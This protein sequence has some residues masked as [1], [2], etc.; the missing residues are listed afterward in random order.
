MEQVVYYHKRDKAYPER[1]RPYP[2]MPAGI[3]T[4][5]RL[6]FE[7][8]P[9]AAIV[10][11]RACS[12]Y[13]RVQARRYARELAAAG[14]QIISGLATGVDAAAH[15][16][17]LEGGG[18]T[19]AVLG[20]GVDIC[21]PKENYPLMR[22]MLEHGGGILSEFE[23]GE[24][25]AAWHFPQR[26]RIISALADL[27]LVVEARKR[28][29]SLITADYALEQGKSVYALPG[30]VNDPLS[31]GCNRLIAQGLPWNRRRCWKSWEFPRTTEFWKTENE[32]W[33]RKNRR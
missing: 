19:F 28:S 8:V 27:V 32:N 2:D 24:E 13:G 18:V 26:N 17:A 15:E 16:G 30:R 3:Y 21:Y 11:A 14:V 31:E 29:G 25:P 12:V 10:G 33:R 9:S 20:C 6:P 23:P 7:G 4:K 5:G 1:M 22:R